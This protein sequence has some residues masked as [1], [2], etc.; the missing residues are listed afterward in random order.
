MSSVGAA[1]AFPWRDGELW[2]EGVAISELAARYGTPLYVYSAAAMRERV[3]RVR[4]A[5]GERASICFAVK[6][7]PNLHLLSM[8]H[9][10]GCGF[11]LVSGGELERLRI[12]GLPA[13][14]AVFAGVAKQGWEIT[15]A[16]AAGLKFINVES[17]HELSML[18]EAAEA[19]G[20]RA[21]VALRV[22]PDVEGDTH[23]YISTGTA[24]S[25]FG[26]ALSV[27][28]GVVDRI[29]ADPWLELVGYHVHLGS[30]L[31][32]A[33]PYRVALDRVLEFVDGDA[34][35]R[36]GVR[37]YDLGG[38]FGISYGD[39]PALDVEEVAQALLPELDRRGWTPVVE[40]G[41]YIVGDAGALITSVIGEK[42]QGGAAFLLVDAAMNDLIRPALYGAEHPI[43]PVVTAPGAPARRVD[44]VGPVCEAGDF[45]GR[46]RSLPRLE[47][48]DLLA[49]LAAGAYGASMSS[50]YNSRPRGAEVLVDGHSYRLVRRRETI[51]SLC[52]DELESQS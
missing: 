9:A 42:D 10:E 21:R 39:A 18:S 12:A 43:V 35:R 31:H 36:D 15:A 50:N 49:V 2:C 24:E 3:R 45:L 46:A 20:T 40:P 23:P 52:N 22:N 16:V 25:K 38:G 32:S 27:A 17:P 6:S 1:S 48:G 44:V 19:A 26:V 51:R 30:Q 13:S 29:C 7:N 28:A 4:R 47:R 34:R 33:M 14:D 5:F 11:D 41:R 8:L 37:Y